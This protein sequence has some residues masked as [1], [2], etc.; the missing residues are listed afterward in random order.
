MNRPDV[1]FETGSLLS[2]LLVFGLV[3]IGWVSLA[4]GQA[5]GARE[6]LSK[7][8]DP[9][10]ITADRM[11]TE[12]RGQKIIFSG[13]VIAR[14]GDMQIKADILEIYNHSNQD[15]PNPEATQL[16]EGQQLDE[17]IAIG[18]VD[19]V[20]GDRRAKGDRAKYLDKEQMI[21][22]SG[23]PKAVAWEGENII[24]GRE[25]I[26]LLESDRFQVNDRV[27]LKIFPK[28]DKKSRKPGAPSPKTR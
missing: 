8:K 21:I 1:F 3:L 19:I 27:R 26:F 23:K 9:I 2:F 17:I 18:N 12:N 5:G 28:N 15:N 24:E 20:R 14:W 16:G 22:L 4:A 13:N 7:R 11:R 10:E 6:E 25:M